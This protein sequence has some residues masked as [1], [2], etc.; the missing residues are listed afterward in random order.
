M[1]RF[2]WQWESIRRGIGQK[3]DP[4]D[5]NILGRSGEGKQDKELGELSSQEDPGEYNIVKLDSNNG[6]SF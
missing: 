5:I 1:S 3:K 6:D 2:G 4:R